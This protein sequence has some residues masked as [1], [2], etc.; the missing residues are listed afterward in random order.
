MA[1]V[2]LN[3]S[4]ADAEADDPTIRRCI[5]FARSWGFGGLVAVNLF[6]WRD[7]HPSGM[8]R[9]ADPVGPEGDAPI[10][11]AARLASLTVAA[12]GVHGAHLGRGSQVAALLRAAGPL[13]HLGLT[14]DGHPRHPLYLRGDARPERWRDA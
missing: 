10:L 14:K 1:F 12:W 8:K 7:T 5:G 9:A 6:A 2:M 13:H 3:P 11:E 4:V